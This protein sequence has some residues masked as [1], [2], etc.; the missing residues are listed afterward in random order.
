MREGF[1]RL[2]DEPGVL[3]PRS[4]LRT[5]LDVRAKR[6]DA[7]SGLAIDQQIDLVWEQVSVLHI[8][9]VP[10]YGSEETEVS[11]FRGRPVRMVTR[12]AVRVPGEARAE[13]DGCRS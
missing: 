5:L 12:E 10:A 2:G 3:E 13:P 6:D 4:A 9:Y 7:K 1:Q 8:I 11:L